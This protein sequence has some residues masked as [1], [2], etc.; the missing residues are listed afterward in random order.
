[1]FQSCT[2]SPTFHDTVQ[3]DLT[4]GGTSHASPQQ[5]DLRLSG[6]PLSQGAASGDR[7]A[8]EGPCRSQGGF[9]IHYSTDA[10]PS[11]E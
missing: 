1:M 7:T 8:S 10:P 9:A 3:R 5:G 2:E 11:E 6:P 4:D